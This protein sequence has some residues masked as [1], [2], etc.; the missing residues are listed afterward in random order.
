MFRG[1]IDSNSNSMFKFI[2]MY[3]QVAFA[4]KKT[5]SLIPSALLIV[6]VFSL[7]ELPAIAI[8]LFACSNVATMYIYTKPFG[9]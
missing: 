9:G 4:K 7:F 1:W 8:H 3:F 2:S 5:S 6:I